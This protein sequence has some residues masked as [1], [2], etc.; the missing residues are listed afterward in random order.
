M[1]RR[2]RCRKSIGRTVFDSVIASISSHAAHVLAKRGDEALI[3][4]EGHSAAADFAVKG[5][6]Q[7]VV[8]PLRRTKASSA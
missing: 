7:A 8:S 1:S 3:P 6:P 5:L 4:T 2:R